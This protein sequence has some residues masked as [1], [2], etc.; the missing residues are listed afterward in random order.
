MSQ[1]LPTLDSLGAKILTL[2]EVI[3][4]QLEAEG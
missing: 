3:G 1:V 4:N 2:E